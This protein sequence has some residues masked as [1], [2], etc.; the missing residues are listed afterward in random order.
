MFVSRLVKISSQTLFG[1]DLHYVRRGR[2]PQIL[3]C[4]KGYIKEEIKI[5]M[6]PAKKAQVAGTWEDNMTKALGSRD[7]KDKDGHN[8]R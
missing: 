1:P 2:R 3:L 8:K 5:L 4:Y 7:K 6:N